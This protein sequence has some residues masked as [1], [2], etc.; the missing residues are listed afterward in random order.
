M[1]NDLFHRL[2][3]RVLAEYDSTVPLVRRVFGDA[4]RLYFGTFAI[5]VAFM[6]AGAGAT[7]GLALLIRHVINTV[8]VERRMSMIWVLSLAIIAVSLIKGGST[9]GQTVSLSRIGNG[10]LATFQRR[11]IDKVLTLGVGY[12]TDQHSSQIVTRISHNARAAR[13]IVMNVSASLGRDLLTVIFLTGVMIYLDPVMALLAFLVIP[14]LLMSMAGLSSRIRQAS[15][16]EYR[17]IAGIAATALETAQG[18]KVVKSFT[19][20]NQMRDRLGTAIETAERR[21]NAIIHLQASRSPIMEGLRGIALSIV[22]IYVGWQ[23]IARSQAPGEFMAFITSLLLAYG[24]A[25]RLFGIN[26]Q[27]QRLLPGVQELYRF[28][29]NPDHEPEQPGAIELT[30][31]EGRVALDHVTFGYREGQPALRDVTVEATP[32]S[33]IAL[34]GPSGAGKTTIVN[35]IQRFYDPWSGTITIDGI[36]IRTVTVASLRRQISVVG[37]D[38]FLFSGTVRQNIAFGYPSATDQEIEAAAEAANAT[39]FIAE[40]P[41]Q[42]ET[43]IGENGASLSGGQRQRIAIA[44][45]VLKNAPILIL[46]EATSAIDVEAEQQVQTA[47]DRL[48]KGR[49]TII[50]AHRLSTVARADQTYAIEA[51]EVVGSGSHVNLIARNGLYYR[52]FGSVS[53]GE[54][55]SEGRQLISDHP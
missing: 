31:V 4:Y 55:A 9:Y 1:G 28:L 20:E 19:A 46:D 27:L 13:E 18:I 33:T 42:F 2:L 29:D 7:T 45:A 15:R 6:V 39:D 26:M 3:G 50:I 14:P 48:M 40:L 11:I 23:T 21:A 41:D 16:A 35:L 17:E 51:G 53:Q 37:Q 10:M 44:R 24:P 12:F 54:S 36:D 5:A 52:L 30:H 49:T 34:V 43:P 25:K 8:V 38:T 47:L 22:I 32:G